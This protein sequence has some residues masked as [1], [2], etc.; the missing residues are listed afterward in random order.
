[1]KDNTYTY[2]QLG[3]EKEDKMNKFWKLNTKHCEQ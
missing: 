3:R 1:M 2:I